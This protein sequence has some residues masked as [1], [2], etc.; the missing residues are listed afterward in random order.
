[1][2]QA[3]KIPRSSETSIDSKRAILRY[4]PENKLFEQ[5]KLENLN[6]REYLRYVDLDR[7]IIL[8]R[9][10]RKQNVDWIQLNQDRV[11]RRILGSIVL[12]LRVSCKT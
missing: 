5:F 12:K 9:I 11:Q 8:K 1:M 10:L 6:I 3:E 4:I 7:W 2:R